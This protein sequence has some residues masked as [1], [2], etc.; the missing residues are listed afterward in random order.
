MTFGKNK[1]TDSSNVYDLSGIGLKLPPSKTVTEGLS[2]IKILAPTLVK[3]EQG[4]KLFMYSEKFY[5]GVLYY[6]KKYNYERKPKDPVIPTVIYR[7]DISEEDFTTQRRVA[8]FT[9]E[10]DMKT[11]INTLDK[12]SFRNIIIED[13]LNISNALRTEPYLYSA[14]TGNIYLIQNVIGGDKSRAINLAYNWYL[15][16]VNLGHAAPEFDTE[17]LGSFPVYVVYG[18]SPALA[19]VIIENQA[20]DSTQYLQLL[21][22]GS[23][24]YTAMLPLL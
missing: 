17:T 13:K 21:S 12:L 20:G 1:V 2:S 8:I 15:Y 3:S 16:K 24:Q 14:P 7:S 23:N 10:G 18:I 22:Y 4:D 5:N 6:L 9:D 11:W 19:P